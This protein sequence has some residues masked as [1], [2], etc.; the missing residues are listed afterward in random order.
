MG[1]GTNCP[2]QDRAVALAARVDDAEDGC[3]CADSQSRV[4]STTTATNP[5]FR[6]KPCTGEPQVRDEIPKHLRL[7][8]SLHDPSVEEM[9]VTTSRVRPTPIGD[10]SSLRRKDRGRELR[11]RKCLGISSRLAVAYKVF[12]RKPG[13]CAVVVITS[14]WESR[15]HSHLSIVNGVLLK[16][17]PYPEQDQLVSL[18]HVSTAGV[19]ASADSCTHLCEH[20]E[21]F[22]LWVCG[23]SVRQRITARETPNRFPA[24]RITAEVLSLLGVAPARGRLFTVADDQPGNP[25]TTVLDLRILAAPVRRR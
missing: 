2:A 21:T 22:R 14:R 17:L 3:G 8:S 9:N 13:F 12:L 7:R 1:Q 5:G 16:P 4:S 6:K 15:N 20:N 18:A 23:L 25:P 11:R 19:A 10:H 24:V